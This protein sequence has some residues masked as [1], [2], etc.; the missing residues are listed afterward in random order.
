M[1]TEIMAAP[2]SGLECLKGASK[3]EYPRLGAPH[4]QSRRRLDALGTP[5]NSVCVLVHIN[6]EQVDG[7]QAN[8]DNRAGAG[9][10]R[11]CA[12]FMKAQIVLLIIESPAGVSDISSPTANRGFVS[13]VRHRP[14][15]SRAL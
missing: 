2:E 4:S 13:S 11:E 1:P 12:D 6:A 8:P 10:W 14:E 5:A 3:G 15:S 7:N 9:N